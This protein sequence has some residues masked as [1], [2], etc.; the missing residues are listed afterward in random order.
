MRR[1]LTVG[2]ILL[3][4]LAYFSLPTSLEESARRMAFIFVIGALFW[5]FEI[6]PLFATALV[7]VL[8]ETFLLL[9]T[10]G[11][12]GASKPDFGLF[13]S[14]F[15]HPVIMLF[16]GG[17][18]LARTYEKFSIDKQIAG[19]L[20]ERF[21]NQ[22]FP[23]MLGFM[24]ATAF[25]SM[26]LSNTA[27]TALMLAMIR[28]V[29][30]SL[31]ARDNLRKAFVLS[32]PFA[33]NLGGIATPVGSPPNAIAMG[34]LAEKGLRLDF[35]SWMAL[36]LPLA[37]FLIVLMCFLIHRLFASPTREILFPRNRDFVWDRDRIFVLVISAVTFFL[38]LTSHWHGIPEG[39]VALLGVVLL[40]FF[41]LVGR[42]DIN[43]IHWD[44]LILMWGGLS[45]GLGMEKSGLVKW[46]ISWPIF[47][48]QG[49][50]LLLVLCL[51]TVF[52]STFVSNTATV[53]LILPVALSLPG[54]NPVL[55]AFLVALSSSFD[56][57]LPISTPP[58]AMAYATREIQ[59]RDMLWAGIWFTLLSNVLLLGM[60]YFLFPIFGIAL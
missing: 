56:F 51:L 14:P 47:E 26:W 52:L 41:G 13:L 49:F 28:P 23:T 59:V 10:P 8:L 55:I 31:P 44:I 5:A 43:R 46:I 25:L 12:L 29:L 40:V 17:F 19:L 60:I 45:L 30:S 38:W 32:I 7:V 34:L 20:M 2:I 9:L 4:F 39:V 18:V 22:S 57:P 21:G 15:S 6:L 54:A 36:A 48:L 50:G 33:A 1:F 3:A 42:G 11:H 35:I 53:T 58:M 24:T 27:T 16:F 37:L